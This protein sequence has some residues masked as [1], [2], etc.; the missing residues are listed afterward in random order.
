MRNGPSGLALIEGLTGE[1]S[2][3]LQSYGIC[4][5]NDAATPS[6]WKIDS[7]RLP[8]ATRAIYAGASTI[9]DNFH[10]G[11]ISEQASHGLSAA[12]TVQN[13]VLHTGGMALQIGRSKNNSL[14]GDSAK[15]TIATRT[16]DS[17]HDQGGNRNWNANTAALNIKGTL[18]KRATFVAHGPFVTLN[19]VL[20]ASASI[21]CDKGT[22]IAGLPFAAVEYSSDVKITNI[23]AQ[24]E[25]GGGYVGGSNLY[26]PAI[27]VG[28]DTLV[29]S[30][31]YIAA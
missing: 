31:T 29:V 10:I 17:W 28:T 18:Q 2:T 13:S 12:G 20:A 21:A 4:F 14:T 16:N 27:S 9:L 24:T 23:S 11:N 8:S 15:W 3:H 6:G 19:L 1:V 5:S 30:A 26:L 22:P 25:L 7:C